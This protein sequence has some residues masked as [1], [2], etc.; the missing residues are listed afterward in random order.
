[1][2]RL[3]RPK[4]LRRPQLAK[5]QRRA[6]RP[7]RHAL[8]VLAPIAVSQFLRP[9]AVQAGLA[10]RHRVAPVGRVPVDTPVAHPVAA[11]AAVLVQAVRGPFRVQVRRVAAVTLE[12]VVQAAVVQAVQPDAVHQRERD[13]VVATAKSCSQ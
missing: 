12:A 11:P 10:I 4:L 9:L 8:V 2:R 6:L 13:V 1:M 7:H 3:L 5:T